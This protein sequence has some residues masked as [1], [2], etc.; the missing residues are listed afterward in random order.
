MAV[1]D[2]STPNLS[3][4]Y[5]LIQ[6]ALQQKGNIALQNEG[7]LGNVAA[8]AAPIAQEAQI[9]QEQSNKKDLLSFK[10]ALDE[11]LDDHQTANKS[12]SEGRM[13]YTQADI[14][15]F[16]DQNKLPPESKPTVKG[17]IYLSDDDIQKQVALAQQRT[18]LNNLADQLDKTDPKRAAAVRALGVPNEKMTQGAAEAIRKIAFPEDDTASETPA[19]GNDIFGRRVRVWPS[20]KQQILGGGAAKE[21]PDNQM[22]TKPENLRKGEMDLVNKGA[23]II[24]K[25]AK[26]LTDQMDRIDTLKEEVADNNPA[27]L[28]NIKAEDALTSGIPGGRLN[29][30]TMQQEGFSKGVADKI[31]QA[32]TQA[33][34]GAALSKDNQKYIL[35][36]LDAK[37]KKYAQH[38]DQAISTTAG[39]VHGALPDPTRVDPDLIT[40]T[41]KKPYA[42][43]LALAV[44]KVPVKGPNGEMGLATPGKPLPAG[45]HYVEQ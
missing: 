10:T 33:S 32:M 39:Q 30:Q 23:Q 25:Q 35:M 36:Y 5:G 28:V 14:D 9:Q 26:P 29:A 16:W 31:D 20:G 22:A 4:S 34:G 8:A 38:L 6:Q 19:T 43:R 45:W 44:S 13:P 41:Y 17:T 7:V 21:V 40:S 37:Q 18:Q 12:A 11:Q 15:A 24:Q 3:G 42:D 1:F 27:A 2:P